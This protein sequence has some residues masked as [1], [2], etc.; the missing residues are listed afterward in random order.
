MCVCIYVCVDVVCSAIHD[1]AGCHCF[2]KILDGHLQEDLYEMP[3]GETELQRAGEPS[4]FKTDDGRYISG[5]CACACM[6]L[7][8]RVFCTRYRA[9]VVCGVVVAGMAICTSGLT[10]QT[11]FFVGVCAC[12]GMCFPRRI[13]CRQP[14]YSRRIESKPLGSGCEPA[15]VFSAV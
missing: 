14:R 13:Y 11:P 15:P 7:C 1:H 9:R 5:V 10:P 4:I 6:R 3:D 12:V 2:M 8:L